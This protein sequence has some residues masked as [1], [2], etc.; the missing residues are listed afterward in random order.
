MTDKFKELMDKLDPLFDRTIAEDGM[1]RVKLDELEAIFARIAELEAKG[2][3]VRVEDR[4]PE[5]RKRVLI[6]DG[7]HVVE[8]HRDKRGGF[9]TG[10][11]MLEDEFL[12]DVTHWQPLPEPPKN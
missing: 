4:L 12:E 11:T 5:R 8:A 7:T 9:W 2:E 3:W 1:Y 10:W 6:T